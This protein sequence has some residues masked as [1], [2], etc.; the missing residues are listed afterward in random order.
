M[1]Q[2]GARLKWYFK[3]LSVCLLIM[4]ASIGHYRMMPLIL[5]YKIKYLFICI[6][7]SGN[8]VTVSCQVRRQNGSD[9]VRF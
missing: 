9:W 8:D 5:Q 4:V 1:L 7:R 6:S 2:I 3:Q